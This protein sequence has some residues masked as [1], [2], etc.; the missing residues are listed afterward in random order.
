MPNIQES[1][2]MKIGVTGGTG[3]IGRYLLRELL[4]QG[5]EVN[6]WARNPSACLGIDDHPRLQWVQGDL[7]SPGSIQ[8]LIAGCDAVVHGA[9]WRP[10]KTFRGTEG[11]VVR[12][13]EV[14][15]V[16]SLRLIDTAFQ[17]GINRFIYVSTC[18]VHEKILA[19]RPLDE[20]HPLWPFSHYGAHK[21][22]VEKFVHS[23]AFGHQY[24][25][26]AIRPTGVYGL[27]HHAPS[28]KYFGLVQS[29]LQGSD[30][31]C[32]RGGKEVH[33]ADVARGIRCLLSAPAD[34]IRGEAFNCYDRYISEFEVAELTKELT[35][36]TSKISGEVKRPRHEI[37]TAKIESLGMQFGGDRL[38]RETLVQLIDQAKSR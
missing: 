25:I 3:F 22:A 34:T 10:G 13:A 32:F 19:D 8:P 26:C 37:E 23:Y 21:A 30:V 2:E 38:L 1:D 24:P 5:Y 16:G 31:D 33:A 12:Y 28:S 7:E 27:C 15:L 14:N 36:S 18:A 9:L 29:I 6:A 4:S 20:A 11:D 35:G 17:A